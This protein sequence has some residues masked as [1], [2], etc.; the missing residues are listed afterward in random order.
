MDDGTDDWTYLVVCR[1]LFLAR[2]F[3]TVCRLWRFLVWLDVVWTGRMDRWTRRLLLPFLLVGNEGTLAPGSHRPPPT[4]YQDCRA[5]IPQPTD[6]GTF[7][8]G[9]VQSGQS[10]QM[11]GHFDNF[12]DI[13]FI[14][15]S[16]LGLWLLLNP[17]HL[18]S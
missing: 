15:F 12:A 16:A 14:C 5:I 18:V 17:L 4:S 9:W 6:C 7:M 10:G 8:G 3:P 13:A 11:D 2:H 1:C